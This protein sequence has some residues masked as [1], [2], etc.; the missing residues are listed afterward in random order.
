MFRSAISQLSRP[1]AFA[2]LKQAVRP[3]VAARYISNA[4]TKPNIKDFHATVRR[5]APIFAAPAVINGEIK[6]FDLKDYQGKFVV[7]VFYPMDFTFVC[8]TE[9]LAFSDRIEEFKSIGAEVVGISCD[10]EFSHLAWANQPRKSGGLGDIKIPLVADKTKYVAYKYGVLAKELGISLRGLFIIDDKG[11][12][13]VSQI[14]DLP[15]GRS[16]DETLRLVEAIQ[17]TDK[18]GEV[19]P[20]NWKK[21]SSTIK[22][23]PVK[24]LEYFE[25]EN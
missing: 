14:N 9:L 16:V 24:S 23:D 5:P 17:F 19:C 3:T 2:A 20:A 15:I 25:K 7:L 18:H 12:I 22:P 8:P 11:V 10:S 6:N 4:S 1:A 21:G 13:R